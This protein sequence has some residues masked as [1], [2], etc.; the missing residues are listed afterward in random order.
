MPFIRQ[1][2]CP[3]TMSSKS[4]DPPPE[5]K[6]TYPPSTYIN[7]SYTTLHQAILIHHALASF[8]ES[9]TQLAK[10][11]DTVLGHPYLF[12]RQ[13][14]HHFTTFLHDNS[15]TKLPPWKELNKLP[16]LLLYMPILEDVQD[17][18]H[19]ISF[20]IIFFKTFHTPCLYLRR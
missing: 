12:K 4:S 17:V 5:R 10:M 8:L 11:S 19:D 13:N 18:L 3:F 16:R 6:H 7:S 14:F 2:K 9:F 1:L 20:S 15:S